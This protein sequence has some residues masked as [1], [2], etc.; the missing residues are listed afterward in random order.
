M[1]Y[2]GDAPSNYTYF[3]SPNLVKSYKPSTLNQ[4]E[5]IV[6]SR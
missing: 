1:P 2:T 6:M 4:L 5:Y 3:S